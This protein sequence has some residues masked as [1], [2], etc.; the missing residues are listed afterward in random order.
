MVE[1]ADAVERHHNAVFIAGFNDLPVPDGAARLHDG[2][3]AGTARA[4]DVVPKG[5]KCVA[6]ETDARDL[7]QPFFFFGGRQR[8]GTCGEGLRPHAVAQHVLPF[9]GDIHVDGVV[10]V[11]A[12][13]VGT[14]RQAQHLG[15][16]AQLPDVRFV[17]RKARTVDAALLARAHADELSALGVAHRVR[18]G[19]F[20]RDQAQRQVPLLL[21]CQR[22]VPCDDIRERIVAELQLVA[23][24]LKRDAEHILVLQRCGLVGWVDGDNV[25]TALAL[26]FQDGQRGGGIARRDNAVRHLVLDDLRRGFVAFVGKGDPV[27]EAGHAVRAA[28]A[29][30]GAGQRGKLDVLHKIHLFQRIIQRQAQRRAG[31][32][33]VL[34]RRG[35]G[36]ARGLAQLFYKLPRVQRVQE[37]DIA[38]FA[39]QNGDGQL[40]LPHEDA[41]GPLVRVAAVFQFQFFHILKNPH[42]MSPAALPHTGR[43]V[44]LFR[45]CSRCG[46][47]FCPWQGR[48]TAQTAKPCCP[49]SGCSRPFL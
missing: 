30:I 15:V 38:R 26:C 29:G 11:G 14:E 18:L 13:D 42:S 47:A 44:T 6:A 8:F 7:G 24:L 36:Q 43:R 2:R 35:R 40:A 22:P 34:E 25:V 1:Q 27:P 45:I 9:V 48:Y 33:D 31:G 10:A 23:P 37:I 17:A 12:G 32:A 16:V 19:V 46:P 41:R 5:E 3:H 4:L 49:R 21:V 20:Q 39:V 28:G